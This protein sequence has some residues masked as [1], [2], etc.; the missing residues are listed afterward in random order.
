M[1]RAHPSIIRDEE[2][3][4]GR[5]LQERDTISECTAAFRPVAPDLTILILISCYLN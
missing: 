4:V 3:T 2:R 5:Y 1:I